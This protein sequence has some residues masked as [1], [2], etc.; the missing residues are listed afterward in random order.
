[1]KMLADLNSCLWNSK[2]FVNNC[3]SIFSNMSL[4]LKL[5]FYADYFKTIGCIIPQNYAS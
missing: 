3:E 4:F 5:L 2:F 1:M